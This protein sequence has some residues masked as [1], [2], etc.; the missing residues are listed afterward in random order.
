QA[1]GAADGP[2]GRP[3]RPGTGRAPCG[4]ARRGPEGAGPGA[5]PLQFQCRAV[6]APRA[7]RLVGRLHAQRRVAVTLP[8]PPP[9]VGSGA[10]VPLR[11]PIRTKAALVRG[12]GGEGLPL[13]VAEVTRRRGGPAR[14]SDGDTSR[15]TRTSWLACP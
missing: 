6:A 5:P 1:R 8:L 13:A 12:P 10:F 4:G 3:R 11:S 15:Q 9:V 7:R 14:W 2:T